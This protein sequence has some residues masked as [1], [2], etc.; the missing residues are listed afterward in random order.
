MDI[1]I[2]NGKH[3]G[4]N[5][6]QDV[7]IADGHIVEIAPRI[8]GSA[9]TVID[10]TNCIVSPGFVDAHVH[11]DKCLSMD[12]I[13]DDQEVETIEEMIIAQRRLKH[14]FT[15]DIVAGRAE[16]AAQM[17]AANGTT[18]TR[19]YVEA[20]PIVEYRAVEGVQL[21]QE[22][23]APFIDIITVCFPQEGWIANKDG[24]ELESRA[25]MAGAMERGIQHVGGNVNRAVWDSNPEQQVDE[26]FE[27]AIKHD[28]DIALHLDNAYNSV[29]F[30]L[31]YVA[32]QAIKHNYQGRVS[33]DHIVS[34]ALVPDR[35]AQQTIELMLEAQV[36]V[37]ILPTVIRLTR[38]QELFEA[39]V[40]VMIGTD[41][42]RDA[43]TH[44]G[45]GNADMLKAMLLMAQINNY[46]SDVQL[47]R[48]FQAGTINPAKALHLESE[49]GLGIGKAADL[50]VIE[51]KSVS[52]A[53]RT[54]APRRAVIKRGR[55]VAEFGRPTINGH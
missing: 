13:T 54:I 38:A 43:F 18:T 42:L 39:G 55:I 27:L 48:L 1:K 10:A 7:G 32:Q 53:I 47:E 11:L 28:A 17:A 51:A 49:Y 26:I 41:N 15:K 36:N 40:N 3:V 29:A 25:Y 5:E 33:A 12:A 23:C 45:N 8:P 35:V 2:Q 46:G 6:I 31:P 19:T 20:D 4:L 44:I 9:R 34:L 30:T 16:R 52:D 37:C 50:V 14:S 24:R 22:R 21:A